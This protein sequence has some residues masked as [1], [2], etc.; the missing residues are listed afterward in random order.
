MELVYWQ[1]TVFIKGIARS[2]FNAPLELPSSAEWPMELHS[3]R[4]TK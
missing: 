3:P 4:E 1:W 2:D